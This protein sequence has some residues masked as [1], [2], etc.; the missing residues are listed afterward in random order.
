V[1]FAFIQAK[2]AQ[3]PV[4]AMCRTLEVAKSGFYAWCSRPEPDRARDDRRLKVQIRASHEASKRRYGSPRIHEDLKAAGEQVS[5][6][7]IARLMKEEGILA[8]RRR[9]FVRTT[10]SKHNLPV[11]PNLLEREFTAE[12][13]NQCWVGDL[14]YLRTTEVWLFLA[15]LLDLFSR[16]VVGWS[17]HHPLET[18]V[19]SRAFEMASN[20]A[21]N[22]TSSRLARAIVAKRAAHGGATD[23]ELAAIIVRSSAQA[24]A[25]RR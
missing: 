7:R 9:R 19:A 2:K 1:R 24:A 8:R 3:F 23:S 11:A 12:K 21:M 6:K 17:I 14:T 16:R 5:R 15:V 25:A 22:E 18:V 4:A 10:D 20:T 13:P